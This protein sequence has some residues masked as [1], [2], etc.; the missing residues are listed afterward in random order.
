MTRPLRIAVFTT[1]PLGIYSGGRYLSM[2]LACALARAGAEV[3]YVTDNAPVFESDFSAESMP[4]FR[5]IISPEMRLPPGTALDWLV[6]IPTGGHDRRFYLNALEAAGASGAKVVLLSFETPNWYEALSPFP[7]SPLPTEAWRSALASGGLVLTIAEAGVPWAEEYYRSASDQILRFGHWYPAINDVAAQRAVATTRLDGFERITAFVRTSDPHKG[8]HDLLSLPPELFRGRILSVIFGRGVD[9]DW[10]WAMRAR[11]AGVPDC[12]IE[13]HEKV[14]DLKKFSILARSSLLLFPSYFEG[15][16]YPPVEAAFMGVPT[17]AYDLPVVRETIGEAGYYASAGDVAGLAAAA[18]RALATA[19][20]GDALRRLMPIAPDLLTSG[21]QFLDRLDAA[22]PLLSAASPHI[23]EPT[24]KPASRPL[25]GR[26]RNLKTQLNPIC[27]LTDL[28][29]VMVADRLVLSGQ[30]RPGKG[31]TQLMATLSGTVLDNIPLTRDGSF[32]HSFRLKGW[33]FGP[34]ALL[35][36]QPAS[37]DGKPVGVAVHLPVSA[38]WEQFLVPVWSGYIHNASPGADDILITVDPDDLVSRPLLSAALAEACATLAELNRRRVLLIPTELSAPGH[39]GAVDAEFL[40]IADAVLRCDEA[41]ALDRLAAARTSGL[42][43]ITAGWPVEEGRIVLHAGRPVPTSTLDHDSA[44]I[45]LFPGSGP[46]RPMAD[47]LLSR[48]SFANRNKVL[49]LAAAWTVE[50][51]TGLLPAAMRATLTRHIRNTGSRVVAPGRIW[52]DRS[53][54]LSPGLSIETLDEAALAACIAAPAKVAAVIPT[55][56][57]ADPLV[58]ALLRQAGLPDP[59]AWSPGDMLPAA[60]GSTGGRISESLKQVV[61]PRPSQH[62]EAFQSPTAYSFVTPPPDPWEGLAQATGDLPLLS[63]GSVITFQVSSAQGRKAIIEGW[64][65]Q[66][67]LGTQ[68]EAAGPAILGFRLAELPP[69]GSG[70]EILLQHF[71]KENQITAVL[72]GVDLGPRPRL[73]PGLRSAVLPVPDR[74]WKTGENF[75]LLEFKANFSETR[76]PILAGMCLAPAGTKVSG[77]V[78]VGELPLVPLLVPPLADAVHVT[79]TASAPSDPV[80][81]MQGWSHPEPTHVWSDGDE[82]LAGFSA[83][84]VFD[85]PAF[86]TLTAAGRGEG[87]ARI[88]FGTDTGLLCETLLPGPRAT[89]L[90]LVVAPSTAGEQIRYFS[91]GFPDLDLLPPLATDPRRLGLALQRLDWVPLGPIENLDSRTEGDAATDGLILDEISIG[92]ALLLTG[93]GQP[94]QNIRLAIEDTSDLLA[95]QAMPTDGW[96]FC[97]PIDAETLRRGV[98]TLCLL[99]PGPLPDPVGLNLKVA[100]PVAEAEAETPRIGALRLRLRRLETELPEAPDTRTAQIAAAFTLSMPPLAAPATYRA[101]DGSLGP[102]LGPGWGALE[103]D[104]VWSAARQAFLQLE[105][106]VGQAPLLMKIDGNAFTTEQLPRQRIV[107]SAGTDQIVSFELNSS[108]K[109]RL[110]LVIPPLTR[111]VAQLGMGFPDAVSPASLGLS[112]DPRPLGLMLRAL[113][114]VPLSEDPVPLPLHSGDLSLAYAPSP[115]G[116]LLQVKGFSPLPEALWLS[117]Q[118]ERVHPLVSGQGWTVW[119]V[120]P[121]ELQEL[122]PHLMMQVTSDSAPVD[123][124]PLPSDSLSD[125][126]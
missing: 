113:T 69:S 90:Q 118:A 125:A 68:M 2:I 124:G 42:P 98:L 31:V 40:P 15:Y 111:P 92:S 79:F 50:A 23:Q 29:A 80:V 45:E 96:A 85:T 20:R 73:A 49:L 46:G 62:L 110:R 34:M 95:P 16:G 112:S 67:G 33:P 48:R 105:R 11:L 1:I 104:W 74:A 94:P 119:L 75:L 81:L 47:A 93:S 17:A 54:V 70:I 61:P 58:L 26:V 83:P 41:E 44:R 13:V 97:L 123:L 18:E 12:G 56:T 63:A 109:T 108:Q 107:L 76:K 14:S 115:E 120:L 88:R 43:V 72:N 8:A 122:R 37:A 84:R 102:L 24:R 21:R 99:G 51:E 36:L 39:A 117:G 10:L 22:G 60:E 65:L 78:V 82:A 89:A 4:A 57:E 101:G 77:P 64:D 66:T 106:P 87:R 5:R 38:N 27:R 100:R 30:A 53:T 3:T 25:T 114:L 35:H 52:G 121:Q 91:F 9:P 71:H 7:R 86:L 6:V 59:T 126:A 28:T 103:Q 116:R 19:P 32:K 55:G